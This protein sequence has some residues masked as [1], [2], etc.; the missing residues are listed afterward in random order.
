MRFLTASL[1]LAASLAAEASGPPAI[2]DEAADAKAAIRATLAEAEK[3]KLPVL[4]VFGAN[5]CGDCRMLDATFK[6]GP[7][8]PLIASSF[9]VVKVD[10]G[11]FDRNV[12]IAEGYRVPLKKGIPA[13]AVLSPQGKLLYATEGGE[14]ANAR[15]M[16]D[17]GVY[18][19]FSRVTASAK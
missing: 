2:Y 16:G 11:R 4:V 14:L 9:K 1:L 10:V 6:T 17:Q 13:V 15:K 18:D 3:A 12:D 19:F 7:S 5:W 8:A